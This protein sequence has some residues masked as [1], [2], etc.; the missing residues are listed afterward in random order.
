MDNGAHF[1]RCDLQVHTPRDRQWE[2]HVPEN[3][4]ER[5]QFA[6]SLIQACRQKGLDAIAVTDHHDFAYFEYIKAA[7]EIELDDDGRPLAPEYRV[8]VFPGMELT[9]AVPCQALLLL[10]SDFPPTLLPTIYTALAL[11]FTDHAEPQCPQ[12]QPINAI[13]LLS[14]IHE[15]LDEHSHLRGRYI[16]LPHVSDGGHKTLLRSNFQA[17]YVEMPCVG[18]YLDGSFEKMGNGA[19]SITDGKDRRYGF[20][21]VGVFQTSDNRRG[22]FADLG[23]H[24]TWIKWAEPT[25]E[26]IRQACL[27]RD[28]RI[29]HTE[30][31]LPSLWIRSIEVNQSRF[32]GPI[33]LDLNQQLSCLIGGRG[34]GK[35]TILEYLRWAL[36]DQPP[37]FSHEDELPDFQAKRAALIKNTLVPLDAVATITVEVNGVVH[38]VRRR[39]N[40]GLVLLKIDD[41]EFEERTEDDIRTLL[42]LQAYSQKQLS[43]VGVR[44]DELVRFIRSPV[45]KQLDEFKNREQE[46]KAEIRK[47]YGTVRAKRDLAR[48]IEREELELG[49]LMKQEKSLRSELKGLNEADQAVLGIHDAF[50]TEE[51]IIGAWRQNLDQVRETIE[52]AFQA[53]SPLPSRTGIEDDS[54]NKAIL[55]VLDRQMATFVKEIKSRLSEL[56]VAV[57][58]GSPLL[59]EVEEQIAQWAGAN[60]EHQAKYEAAKQKASSQ[61]K[62][63]SQIQEVENRVKTVRAS[64]SSK[65][66]ALAKHGDPEGSYSEAKSQWTALYRS[67]ADLLAKKCDELTELSGNRIRARLKRGS[68][69]VQAQEKFEGMITGTRIRSKKVEELCSEVANSPDPLAM[70]ENVLA[71]LECLAIQPKEEEVETGIPDT[72]TLSA[73]DFSQADLE[74]LARKITLDEWLDLSLAELTDV[75]VFEYEQREGEYIPFAAASAGQQATA[76]LRVLLNQGGPPL[77][78]DQPEEDLDNQV[79]LE[80]VED[81]WRAKKQRQVIFSSHNANIVV[82]GDADLVVCCDY[83]RAGD[84]SGGQIE[85]EGAIDIKEIRQGITTV[86]EGGKDAFRLRKEKYGF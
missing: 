12:A 81:V 4:D 73:A 80:I 69:V 43:A 48:H 8:T 71:E 62:L 36:C 35:S 68:G 19:K 30:P 13:T 86:M 21:K 6:A 56:S 33:A 76:L 22:D 23:K 39:S 63:L 11:E 82:N 53:V 59:S 37:A 10:D 40:D 58:S 29:S 41:G 64:L 1:Y 61:Q 20:K 49:S 66:A 45:K 47:H 5:R 77:I 15:R 78:I 84:Q 67:R 75:P 17:K 51:E 42:P 24:S 26:A 16:V 55:D 60:S 18:G 44:A 46:L 72:L 34:T 31:E 3:D 83:R 52:G 85:L 38:V 2:G 79:V 32:L 70:W 28:T 7:A 74:K 65:K 27:A 14:Q 57:S 25:A 54:P 50:V 9:L